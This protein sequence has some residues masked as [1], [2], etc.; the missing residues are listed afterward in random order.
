MPATSD[1]LS[2]NERISMRVEH[3]REHRGLSVRRLAEVMGMNYSSLSHRLVGRVAWTVDD[4][5][6]LRRKLGEDV[7]E[8]M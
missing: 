5:V 2:V 1:N 4:V 6:T 3:M 7:L 8:G